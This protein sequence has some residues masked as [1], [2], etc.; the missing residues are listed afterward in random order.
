MTK[1]QVTEPIELDTEVL[2]TAPSVN[3][4]TDAAIVVSQFRDVVA[5]VMNEAQFAIISGRTPKSVIKRRPGKGGKTFSYVPHGYVTATLN[6]AFGFHWS[7]DIMPNGKGDFYTHFPAE[8]EQSRSAS[9]VVIGKLTVYVHDPDDRSKVLAVIEKTSTG[10]KEVIKGM[11]W[12]G[13]LKSAESDALK[14]AASRLGI[15][16]DLYWQDVDDDYDAGAAPVDPR[17]AQAK[18]LLSSGKNVMSI[19]REMSI[20]MQEASRLLK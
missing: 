10:E 16:L 7:F 6:K 1:K 19:A 4:T 12:G 14:K 2:D 18:A 15:G 8:P 20:T 3:E 13:M 17:V 9:I 5:S 11:S